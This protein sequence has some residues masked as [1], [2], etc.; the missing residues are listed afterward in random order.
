MGVLIL[1]STI[2][3]ANLPIGPRGQR[4][5]CGMV[6][7]GAVLP[8]GWLLLAWLIPFWGVDRLHSAVQRL[9]FL[10]FGMAVV[11]GLC[12]A[13]G[14]YLIVLAKKLFAEAN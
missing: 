5:F 14:W 4:L 7:A 9:L 10:P 2:V 11:I 1:L 12:G 13:F 8:L 6:S 3:I